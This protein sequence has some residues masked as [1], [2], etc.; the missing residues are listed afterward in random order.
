[1][2]HQVQCVTV[3]DCGYASVSVM[4]CVLLCASV[5]VMCLKV[6][7][8]VCVKRWHTKCLCVVFLFSIFPC[9]RKSD[10]VV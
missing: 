6:C 8:C 4:V 5:C 3:S 9:G 7:V 2:P 1:M 10:L